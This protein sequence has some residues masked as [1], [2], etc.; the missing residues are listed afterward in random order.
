MLNYAL[1]VVN[2][3]LTA[4][5]QNVLEIV[6]PLAGRVVAVELKSDTTNATGDAVFDVHLNGA[7]IFPDQSQRP[8][9]P[10]AAGSGSKTGLSVDVE[11]FDKLTV[12]L[13]SV[14]SSGIGGKLYLAL[15]IEDDAANATQIRGYGVT[16]DPPSE[17]GFLVLNSLTDEFE[18]SNLRVMLTQ[19][20]TDFYQGAFARDPTLG[21]MTGDTAELSAAAGTG[22]DFISEAVELGETVFTS[23]EYTARA[24]TDAEYAS[25][26]YR[27]YLARAG[28]AGEITSTVAA[29]VATNRAAVRASFAASEEFLVQRVGRVYP[30]ALTG[31]DAHSLRGK[32]LSAA[33]PADG[34]GY[35]YDAASGLFVPTTPRA[36]NPMT[37][38]G[39]I[40][41]GGTSGAEQRLAKGANGEVLTLV[42]GAPAWAAAGGGS[43]AVAPFDSTHPDAVPSSPNALDDE[44][45]GNSLNTATKWSWVNQ[46]STAA[47]VGNRHLTL[48]YGSGGI[49]QTCGV[50]QGISGA[51][52]ARC[53]VAVHSHMTAVQG[54]LWLRQSSDGKIVNFHL[55]AEGGF[56]IGGFTTPATSSVTSAY[57]STTVPKPGQQV[58]LEIEEDATNRHFRYS[59]TGADGTFYT[60]L[61][62]AKATFLT[63]NEIGVS[64]RPFNGAV[65]AAFEW[66][67]RIS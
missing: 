62:H 27:A 8:K 61:S 3:K 2:P 33:A 24:R 25:D 6:A 21:E 15:V 39:D 38:A 50:V 12:D 40:I 52:K 63:T 41:T 34:Q 26:L 45:N 32:K 22:L 29:V 35:R 31:T 55:A 19:F 18:W 43:S 49:N 47:A 60:L 67:R 30:N 36:A 7:T 14:N 5:A 28:T 56:L 1:A 57:M 53:K 48:V 66:F 10:A 4:A 51:F 23:A 54:G 58:Y 64:I 59:C 46:Q 11:K 20:I 9:I 44:F 42:S 13:D 16:D 17:G 65:L 37:A